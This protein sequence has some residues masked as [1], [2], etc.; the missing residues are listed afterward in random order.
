MPQKTAPPSGSSASSSVLLKGWK[1]IASFLGL[2][3]ST[4]QRWAKSGMPI[5][6]EG[7]RVRASAE[8]LNRWIGRETSEPVHIATESADLSSELRRGLSYVK[9]QKKA[10][11]KEKAA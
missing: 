10:R 6:R 1:E 8:E 5:S 11:N 2:P 3:I 4:A 9:Q 7:Q